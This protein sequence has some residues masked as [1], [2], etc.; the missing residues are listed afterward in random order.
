MTCSS[1]TGDRRVRT[2]RF[3]PADYGDRSA[4]NQGWYPAWLGPGR[5]TGSHPPPLAPSRRGLTGRAGGCYT[6][7]V[8]IGQEFQDATGYAAPD[9][10]ELPRLEP[11][12]PRAAALALPPVEIEGPG[13]FKMLGAR[14]SGR[15]Y[16]GEVLTRAELG[17]LCWA[18]Q[19]VTRR[20][21][22]HLLRAAPSAGALYALDLLVALPG[23]DPAAGVWRYDPA[24][25]SLVPVLRGPAVPALAGAALE[26]AFIKRSAAVFA[27]V[28]Q[29]ERSVWK[30]EERAWRYFYL[31]AGHIG[32]NLM[33]AAGALGLASCGVGAFSDSAVNQLLVLDGVSELP[34]YLVAVGRPRGGEA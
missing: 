5:I 21:G 19:G 16:S 14:R 33:L 25:H 22:E 1:P 11:A 26:Q 34:V 30:Y 13:L 15:Q 20:V 32:E 17:A 31:D 3:A 29:P 12:G 18:A 24:G 4:G 8:G 23:P 9:G 6:P 10:L 2:G 7:R 27:M 28:A